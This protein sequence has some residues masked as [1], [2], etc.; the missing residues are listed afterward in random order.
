MVY[1]DHKIMATTIYLLEVYISP[2]GSSDAGP[3]T[4]IFV[5]SAN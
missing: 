5:K 3:A 4:I 1:I 2:E